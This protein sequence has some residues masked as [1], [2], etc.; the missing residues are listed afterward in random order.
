MLFLIYAQPLQHVIWEILGGI[1]LWAC[2][3]KLV[4]DLLK[5]ERLWRGLNG[6]LLAAA[7]GAILY[8]TVLDRSGGKREVV[9]TPFHSF[10]EA[11]TQPELYRAMLMNV[12]LFVPFGLALP[13]C[14]PQ[15]WSLSRRVLWTI[16][17][18][19]ALSCG[20]ELVQLLFRLGRTETDDVLCNTLG[21]A[22]AA[23]ASVW[24]ALLPPRHTASRG[25]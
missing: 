25:D 1:L 23:T 10:V 8:I 12:L 4:A 21:T 6:L 5:Q 15:G 24:K 18:G 16:L 22:L 9:L 2:L 7:I 19:L 3:G 20:M 17:C 14:L 13:A 11:R